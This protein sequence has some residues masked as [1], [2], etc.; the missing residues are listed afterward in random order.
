MYPAARFHWGAVVPEKQG[1]KK[2]KSQP[3]GGVYNTVATFPSSLHCL[4]EFINCK[5]K[6]AKLLREVMSMSNTS[7]C[8]GSSSLTSCFRRLTRGG[9]PDPSHYLRTTC[10]PRP[11]PVQR[12]HEHKLP[13]LPHPSPTLLPP[14][15]CIISC[16]LTSPSTPATSTST[17]TAA[18]STSEQTKQQAEMRKQDSH[19][20]ED[21]LLLGMLD[22]G[23]IK[24]DELSLSLWDMVDR[25]CFTRCITSL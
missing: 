21:Q 17:T 3:F 4:K 13:P 24:G 10:L 6:L 16:T 19:W 20:L 14:L 12:N 1:E 8:P 23:K 2:G 11:Q 9:R 25:T 22:E 5:G 7:L 18:T 15:P